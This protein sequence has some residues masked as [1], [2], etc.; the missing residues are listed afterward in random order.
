LEEHP[1]GYVLTNETPFQIWPHDPKRYRKPDGAFLPNDRLPGG[2]LPDGNI[3]VVPSL[4]IEVVSPTDMAV[5]LEAKIRDYFQAGVSAAWVVYPETGA[6]AVRRADGSATWLGAD[7]TLS[8]GTL[9]PGFAVK[10]REIF[11]VR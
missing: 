9:I 1:I 6:V 2:E 8:G 11:A 7:D 3:H 5:P 4:V 10:V